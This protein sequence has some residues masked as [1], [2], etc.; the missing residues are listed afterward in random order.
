MALVAMQAAMAQAPGTAAPARE[1]RFGDTPVWQDEFDYQGAPDPARWG[2]DLGGTGWG[3]HEL[4]HYTDQLGNAFV[5]AGVLAIVARRFKRAGQ[6]TYTSARL[7]SRGKGDFL[8]GRIEFRARLPVGRGTWGALWML[9]TEQHYGRWPRSGEIDIMEHVGYD[10][11]QVHVT[12]HTQA[13]NHTIRTQRGKQARVDDHATKFHRYRVD[14][15]PDWIRGYIDDAPVFE[16]ANEGTGPDAWPFD[17][18]FH[19][20]MNLAVGGDWGGA[21]GVDP[22]AFPAWME[23]DYVRVYPLLQP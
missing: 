17:R 4:Q 13:Y 5:E 11:G 12:V 1:W 16:F 18:P 15:T 8:Y 9:P 7:V 23:V 6:T 10:P 2:Y 19:L 22:D 14:W 3:N 20:L 21:Q